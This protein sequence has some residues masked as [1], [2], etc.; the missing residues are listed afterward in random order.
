MNAKDLLFICLALVAGSV[1]AAPASV[2]IGLP[3]NA[4]IDLSYVFLFGGIMTALMTVKADND[5]KT[6]PAGKNK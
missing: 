4:A 2:H 3:W 6:R 5:E 1:L